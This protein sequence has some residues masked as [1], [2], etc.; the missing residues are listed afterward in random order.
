MRPNVQERQNIW[1]QHS[2]SEIL[3][4]RVCKRLRSR[5]R[6]IGGVSDTIYSGSAGSPSESA[7]CGGTDLTLGNT[8]GLEKYS[9]YIWLWETA[10]ESNE[11]KEE[12]DDVMLVQSMVQSK[13]Y[14]N[15]KICQCRFKES[16]HCISRTTSH[17][18]QQEEHSSKQATG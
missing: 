14:T 3:E 17:I 8:L 9:W 12:K 16:D 15:T 11:G 2:G 18:L 7:L 13:W 5:L 4:S 6:R 1:I 10:C